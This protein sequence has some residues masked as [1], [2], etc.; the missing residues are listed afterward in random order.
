M[1]VRDFAIDV[2]LLQLKSR[3]EGEVAIQNFKPEG[4]S[5]PQE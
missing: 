1:N 4:L 5:K 3:K 2:S